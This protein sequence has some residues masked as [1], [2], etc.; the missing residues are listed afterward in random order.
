MIETIT[1]ITLSLLLLAILRP[2]KTPP[3]E[4]PLAIE[5]AGQYHMTLAPKLNL[6]QGFVEEVGKRLA[7]GVGSSPSCYFVVRDKQV[8]AH[9]ADFYLL[10]ATRRNGMMYFQAVRPEGGDDASQLQVARTFAEQV[11]GRF[12]AEGDIDA[13][14]AAIIVA[15]VIE[16][17]QARGIEAKVLAE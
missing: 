9:G 14:Q 5:R 8:V 4:S 7:G 11:L 10:A 16:S 12:P 3:L 1:L 2:G 15:A 13:A 17:A 6:A